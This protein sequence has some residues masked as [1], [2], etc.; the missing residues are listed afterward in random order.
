MNPNAKK[1]NTDKFDEPDW[2]IRTC[3]VEIARE[4]EGGK[5]VR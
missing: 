3:A 5:V 1:V 4:F 2:M